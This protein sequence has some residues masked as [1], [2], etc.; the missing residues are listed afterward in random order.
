M[1]G[2]LHKKN[3]SA[4]A[5]PRILLR[6]LWQVENIGDVAHAPGMLALLE[7]HFPE[8]EVTVWPWYH[9]VPPEESAMLRRRFP[10]VRIVEG[11]LDEDGRGTTPELTE[12][13]RTADFFLHNS[14][15]ATLGWREAQTFSRVTGRPFGVYGVTYGLYGIPEKAALSQAR[16]VYFRDSV[17]LEKA[18]QDGVRAPLMEFAPDAAFAC[19]VRDDARAA[20]Y[21][22]ANELEPGRFVCCLPKHRIT[23]MWLH[24]RKNREFNRESHARNEAMRRHDHAPLIEAITTIAR[25]TE[26]KILIG[27]EDITE[28]PI[29]KEWLL[30]E[31]PADVK[32][33]VVWRDTPWHL[34]EAVSIYVRSAGLFGHE[35]HSPIMCIGNGIPA[36]VGRWAEQSSKGF[37]WRDIGLNDWLFDMDREEEV[38]KVAS[39]VLALAQD[40]AAARVRAEKARDLV[41]RRFA[42]TMAVVRREVLAAR[43]ARAAV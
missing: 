26:H 36:I 4:P 8:A 27:H 15:P 31:L 9:Y 13:I 10:R 33:R 6:S 3:T 19:D 2:D 1:N 28:L 35:M 5:P 16:F 30:D 41:R 34:A 20:A 37:M 23:P 17:S 43:D 22:K 21:L 39:T 18:R 32:P 38:R 7:N 11:K 29:G 12:A 40:P 25:E 14:G 42:E 24:Q